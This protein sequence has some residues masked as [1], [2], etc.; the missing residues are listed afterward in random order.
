M[1]FGLTST[2]L[3]TTT[4][5]ATTTTNSLL[6][7]VASPGFIARKGKIEIMSWVLTVDFGAGCSS[8]SMT[9]VT[10]AVL[11]GTRIQRSKVATSDGIDVAGTLVPFVIRSSCLA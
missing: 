11:F 10:K 4:A 7:P 3:N 9:N 6:N 5:A 8:C 1:L 2:T